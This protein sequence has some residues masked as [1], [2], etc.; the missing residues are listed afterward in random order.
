MANH[1]LHVTFWRFRQVTNW[2]ATSLVKSEGFVKS[3]LKKAAEM[4]KKQRLVKVVHTGE[5]VGGLAEK[6][7][8]RML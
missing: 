7:G 8:C 3:V 5:R 4:G 2:L 1:L 6:P